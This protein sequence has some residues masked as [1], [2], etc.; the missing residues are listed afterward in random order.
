[1]IGTHHFKERKIKEITGWF[2]IYNVCW[3]RS[4]KKEH[5]SGWII[6]E[7]LIGNILFSATMQLNPI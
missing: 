7:I 4:K 6:F 1:M 5:I 2:V 3:S